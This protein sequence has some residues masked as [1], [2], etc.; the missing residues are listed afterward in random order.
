MNPPPIETTAPPNSK[1]E[2]LLDGA[3]FHDSWVVTSTNV[4]ASALE[5][6]LMAVGKTPRWVDAC[7]QIRNSVVQLFGLKDLG[8]LASLDKSKKAMDYQPGERVGIFT[9]IENTWDE[10]LLGDDDKHLKVV[11]SIHRQAG[12]DQQSIQ[13]TITTVV[14]TKN[15]L[16]RWYMLPV[17]P[18]HRLIAP[19]MLSVMK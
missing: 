6:F 7:M 10:V 4:S 12:I 11:V 19:A 2:K 8:G 16:G 13:V 14:H 15:R 17:K 1:V 5:L 9:L 3:S 18:M